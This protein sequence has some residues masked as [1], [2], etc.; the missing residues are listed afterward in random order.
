M[1]KIFR[2]PKDLKKEVEF[3]DKNSRQLFSNDQN[4]RKI[5]PTVHLN[6]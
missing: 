2:D 4:I 5:C 6:T 1:A 3:F